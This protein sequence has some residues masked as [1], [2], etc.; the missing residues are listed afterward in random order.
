MGI[1][2]PAVYVE[3]KSYEKMKLWAYLG[4][5]KNR[6]FICFATADYVDWMNGFH[7]DNVYLVDQSGSSGGVEAEDDAM[8]DLMYD[9]VEKGIDIARLRCWIH[10]HPGTGKSATFLS[11]TDEKN[12]ERWLNGDFLISIV[13][14]SEGENP[15]TRVD[16]LKPRVNFISSLEVAGL[17][18]EEYG[19]ATKE[20]ESKSKHSY[21]YS[22]KGGTV[23]YGG[24][25]R[26]GGSKT[27]KDEDGWYQTSSKTDKG[28]KEKKGG[29]GN[30]GKGEGKKGK[31]GKGK[32]QK[33]GKEKYAENWERIFE[34]G[35][36]DDDWDET[37]PV[38]I[39]GKTSGDLDVTNGFQIIDEDDTD[40]IKLDVKDED[41]LFEMML[42]GLEDEKEAEAIVYNCQMGALSQEDG[43]TLLV[44]LGYEEGAARKFLEEM[45]NS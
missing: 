21:S 22:V 31:K 12:I 20:F 41:E 27:W 33:N 34:K 45:L 1:I 44:S 42:K 7:I 37:E 15:Y 43:I 23:R 2:T 26:Y 16:L 4:G 9:L 18:Q 17:T 3:P 36:F 11:P 5:K 6:E 30:G 8:N 29:K 25:Y 13:W 35:Y 40:S 39:A 10:S 24:Y 28:D 32:K 14:D 38:A 19:E